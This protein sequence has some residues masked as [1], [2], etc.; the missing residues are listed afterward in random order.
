MTHPVDP[1][2]DMIGDWFLVTLTVGYCLFTLIYGTMFRW[3]NNEAGRVFFPAKVLMSLVMIQVTLSSL[4][5][6]D[7]PYRDWVRALLYGLGTLA[8]FSMVY[9]LFFLI[10]QKHQLRKKIA[11]GEVPCPFAQ[12]ELDEKDRQYRG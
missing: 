9:L 7:Y 6:S 4:T 8:I 12:D 1:L 5:K 3:W 11:R 2:L 10:Y